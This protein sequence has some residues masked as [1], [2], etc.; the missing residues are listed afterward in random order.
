M[1]FTKRSAAE[2]AAEKTFNKL[3]LGGKKLSIRWVKLLV[4]GLISFKVCCFY[5]L[6]LRIYNFVYPLSKAYSQ[7]KQTTP[8]IQ[9][10][11]Q[12]PRLD[13][14]PGLPD[15]PLPPNPNDYFNLNASEMLILPAGELPFEQPCGTSFLTIFILHL[16]V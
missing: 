7:A 15:L 13:P 14:V 6:I 1:Q 12:D 3:V 5:N 9:K 4:K 11:R 10:P 8:A 16:K 2:L